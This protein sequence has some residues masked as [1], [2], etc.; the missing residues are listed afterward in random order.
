MI[1]VAFVINFF[2]LSWL[3]GFNVIK[4]LIKSVLL[5][6]PDNIQIILFVNR[7]IPHQLI[8]DL[9]IKI[10]KTDFFKN[11]SLVE[12]VVNKLKILIFGKSKKY[13][14]FFLS[15]KID[16]VSHFIPLGRNSEIKSFSWITDFQELY[17]KRYFTFREV[18]LRRVNFYYSIFSSTKIILSS[19]SA[20]KDLKKI[21]NLN[22][23]K[24]FI[25]KFYF[26]NYPKK[27]IL[28]FKKLKKKFNIS[29]KYFFLPNQYW[30]HKNH[31]LVIEAI[32]FLKKKYNTVIDVVSSGNNYAKK[33]KKYFETVLSLRD[34]YKLTKNYKYVGII[35]EKELYSLMYYS[36]AII[37]PS[38]FEG[39]N[40]SVM[41]A[42]A[43]N[44]P[45]V[46]SNISTH[47]EQRLDNFFYFINNNHISL[48]QTILKCMNSKINQNINY[49][50]DNEKKFKEYGKKFIMIV[51]SVF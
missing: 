30:E 21:F 6:K 12:K 45:A 35:S 23:K 48:A 38:V 50:C 25:H 8:S 20:H 2:P 29:K 37:N 19:A 28:N 33:S 40:T 26:G 7:N 17:Y 44:K 43:L 31:I 11:I 39:W 27:D 18:L 13:D 49:N 16:L 42:A 5:N 14:D 32:N 3:G 4:N 9:N 22:S 46:L 10:I 24:I 34:Q 15:H 41:Q 1:K 36:L 47:L 51:K